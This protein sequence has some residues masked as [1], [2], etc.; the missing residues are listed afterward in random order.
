MS[1]SLSKG[2]D[3]VSQPSHHFTMSD[4]LPA[5]SLARVAKIGVKS[6]KGSL[7]A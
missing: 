4:C 3:R 2:P 5:D 6:M 1:L 7:S